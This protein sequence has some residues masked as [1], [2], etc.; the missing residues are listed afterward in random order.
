MATQTITY[1]ITQV[2]PDEIKIEYSDGGY[3]FVPVFADDTREEIIERI[4]QFN[5]K[6]L[7]IFDSADQVPVSLGETGTVVDT[8][9]EPVNIDP[10]LTYEDLRNR[11]Y[12]SP[13]AVALAQRQANLGNT[14]PL[15]ALWLVFD[16]VEAEFPETMAPILESVY[17]ASLDV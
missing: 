8:R 17:L 14:A 6:P 1:E 4:S 7:V 13:M 2:Q 10:L 11:N 16:E 3:A 5:P 9:Q 12:P 15:E